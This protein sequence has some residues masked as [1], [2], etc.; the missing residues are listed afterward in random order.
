M[1]F[2][3]N[4]KSVGTKT[5]ALDG[6]SNETT[7]LE[8]DTEKFLQTKNAKVPDMNQLADTEKFPPNKKNPPTKHS[9]RC[10]IAI[11]LPPSLAEFVIEREENQDIQNL[12]R[13]TLRFYSTMDDQ[14]G[15]N[16]Y[17]PVTKEIGEDDPLENSSDEEE[18]K[19]NEE[20]NN[21]K[22]N[23]ASHLFKQQHLIRT[24]Y[25]WALLD[26]SVPACYKKIED[27]PTKKWADKQLE[28]L[29]IKAKSDSSISWAKDKDDI[30]E[31]SSKKKG[32]LGS[33][34][35]KHP[36]V[37]LTGHEMRKD[38][39]E[40]GFLSQDKVN[41]LQDFNLTPKSEH[42]KFPFKQIKK[43]H[44]KD[45]F[46]QT[47]GKINQNK[48]NSP[49]T[50]S[51]T[52]ED[53][54]DEKTED[55][56]VPVQNQNEFNKALLLTVRALQAKIE[57]LS[58]IPT[59]TNTTTSTDNDPL[60]QLMATLINQASNSAKTQE[61]FVIAQESLVKMKEQSKKDKI[62][63]PVEN[64][65]KNVF[66]EDGSSQRKEI[67]PQIKEIMSQSQ[68]TAA[69]TLDL[70]LHKER[71]PA[72]PM[73]GFIKSL[74]K[75]HYSYDTGKPGGLNIMS[76]PHTLNGSGQENININQLLAAE[77]NKDD[78]SSSE[79]KILNS[80]TISPPRTINYAIKML[81]AYTSVLKLGGDNS[82]IF[83]TADDIT[84]WAIENEQ[85][86]SDNTTHFDKSLPTKMVYGIGDAFNSYYKMAKYTVPNQAWLNLEDF[87]M[88]LLTNQHS[89][90]L[91]ES[92]QNMTDNKRK[93]ED[94]KGGGGGNNNNNNNS[95]NGDENPQ[96]KKF[97]VVH[98][99]DQPTQLKC[100]QEMHKKV[101]NEI[102]YNIDN[103]DF[104]CP[105]HNGEEECLRYALIGVCNSK[106]KRHAS[107]KPIP[108]NSSR[109]HNM[110]NFRSKALA[111][112]NK[113]KKEG[114]QN[115]V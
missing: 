8:I 18:E 5:L 12:Y 15:I 55:D 54:T 37:Q 105:K 31:Q 82:L 108:P 71:T 85:I 19:S 87:K 48:T 46:D 100:S 99:S 7:T 93:R 70:C 25:K 33:P 76:I 3:H 114:D 62:S 34:T 89:S 10:P 50:I 64:F 23:E 92:I 36:Q 69:L 51:P 98:H 49:Q 43:P 74:H 11:F 6:W 65:I 84:N 20:V 30:S 44:G 35:K 45:P 68:D 97:N 72:K 94:K 91:P 47:Q 115:F 83:Q 56:R 90:P 81:A 78:L 21:T 61:R 14:D 110:L 102:V 16:T 104:S 41:L 63:T 17:V 79:K 101:I 111:E 66:T 86:L 112:Y 80:L 39:P 52:T 109:F 38:P 113:N 57:D 77:S 27:E 67:P 2:F 103:Y 58:A 1:K 73:V 32:R 60:N 59:S 96:K 29:A 95:G 26:K 4:I 28:T 88:K 22:I 9:F 75:G 106:C 107:H 13:S 40:E 42:Q 24:L 53:K